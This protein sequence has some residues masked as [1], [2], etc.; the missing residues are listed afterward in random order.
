MKNDFTD[1]EPVMDSIYGVIKISAFEKRLLNS[2]EMQRL[3]G[4]K[5]LGFVSLVYP[6][7]EHSR[8]AHSIGV[9]H[10]AKE[11]VDIIN[12][13]VGTSPRYMRWRNTFASEPASLDQSSK[14][15]TKV[16]RII[17]AAAALLHDLPHSPFSHEI[18]SKDD[19]KG[20][21]V[22]DDFENNPIFF[23]YLFNIQRSELAR[24]IDTYNNLFWEMLKND[25]K[26]SAAFSGKSFVD[27]NGYILIQKNA[28]SAE[29]TG[30]GFVAWEKDAGEMTKLPVLGAMI[31]EVLLFDKPNMWSVPGNDG[32]KI[33]PNNEGVVVR[34]ERASGISLRWRP[35]W[36][37]YRP[38]RKDIIA[39]T[40]CS[41]LL[42]YLIRDGKNTGI[43]S[44]LD[45]KFFDRMTIMKAYPDATKKLI[46]LVDL[47]DFC[48]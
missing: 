41:D 27:E 43:L 30:E 47:P 48:E 6:D 39:N 25:S 11:M 38:Y 13:N 26:W 8:L 1:N 15:I 14:A 10:K 7:A 28:E 45:L 31:F 42:D 2:Q 35:E 17:I 19:R 5:Q 23:E 33:L 24:V 9:C 22:H 32:G 29:T 3:R 16:E 20:I 36:T 46:P 12:S 40:I 34:V 44:S 21:P 4:I 18:E 37:W